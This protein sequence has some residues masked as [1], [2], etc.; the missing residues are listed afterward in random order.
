MKDISTPI[1]ILGMI[2]Y[3]RIQTSSG[4]VQSSGNC[5]AWSLD[6]GSTFIPG[7]GS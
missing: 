1:Y 7:Q 2:N 5:M 6:H 4:G 3:T